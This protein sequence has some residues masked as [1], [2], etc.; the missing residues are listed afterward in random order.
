MKSLKNALSGNRAR[1]SRGHTMRKMKKKNI[2]NQQKININ[3]QA[4]LKLKKLINKFKLI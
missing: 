1:A 2:Y 4:L 3:I